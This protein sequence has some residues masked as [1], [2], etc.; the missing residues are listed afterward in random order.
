MSSN[1]TIAVKNVSKCYRIFDRPQDR[2]K[3][4][5]VKSKKKYYK[6]FWALKE[7]SFEIKKGQ[8]IGI[9]GRNGSGKS[10]ILQIIA[11][12]LTP[13]SGEVEINGRVAAL[14]ELG[15]G[16]NPE[17]TGRENIIMNCSIMG[18]T[19]AEIQERMQLI[20]EFAEIGDFINRPV[21]L[22]SS[23][24]Y[25]RLAFACAI[26]VDPDI[27]VIDEALAVGDMRF[28]LKCMDKIKEFQKQG[29]TILFVSHDSYSVRNICDQ[30][31]WMID[32]Q[33]YRRGDAKSIVEQYQD[34]MKTES[35]K[36][37]EINNNNLS[38]SN[39]DVLTIKNIK[40][41][42]SEGSINN[43]I[44]FKECFSIEVDYELHEN[45]KGLVGGIAIY[46]SQNNYICGLNTKLDDFPICDELGV[47]SLKLDYHEI[48]LMPGTYYIDVGFFESSAI[49]PLAYSSRMHSFRIVSGE[50]FAEGMVFFEH[51]WRIEGALSDAKV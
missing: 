8:T 50:Y 7:V 28:Q 27:L 5:F 6:E 25:V 23:G 47:H 12:T 1:I 51:K 31:I 45:T 33:I 24:M 44:Q 48:N 21:K 17:F 41:I 30:A 26:N 29:K 22:Y 49:V 34:F 40:V 32:G 20:E 42:D 35:K 36:V 19:S 16:F 3:Q 10:T 15:S 9:I 4:S 37:E 38:E 11:K 13:T 14:L 46:D 18:L 43:V 39:E 2:L